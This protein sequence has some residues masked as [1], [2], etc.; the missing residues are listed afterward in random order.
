MT[1]VELVAAG[2]AATTVALST[3]ILLAA[4]GELVVE[5]SGVINVG[6]EGMM[7]AGAYF[8]YTS[9][10]G[11]TGPR[12]E[13]LAYALAAA[14]VAGA[15]LGAV[16]ALLALTFRADQVVV[17][18]AI[19]IVSLGITGVLYHASANLGSLSVSNP[20]GN[21]SIPVLEHVPVLG[22]ALFQQNLLV[23]A[24][25]LLTP[26]CGWYLT[27]TRSG[28]R[29]RA[30]G[31]Y[32]PAADSAG[33]SV[34]RVRAAALLLGGV[35]SGLAGAYL[36]TGYTCTFVQGMS[37]GKG[38]MALAVVIVGRWSAGG[39]LMASL[40]FGFAS[41]L[42]VQFQSTSSAVPYQLL[43]ALPYLITI[44]A[45]LARRRS[46]LAPMSLGAVYERG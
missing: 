28:L 40:L 27:K 24:A 36:S 26:L 5:R 32:P 1:G 41:A 39:I 37:S 19:N 18:T 3:P 46:A 38:F 13:A 4:L 29:L 10:Q 21:F 22:R 11:C 33:V 16:F 25:I 2:L 30:C 14:A 31:E 15:V 43:L 35:L 17:G 45:L 23:Y 12:W 6:M 8:A 20:I 9:A 7:L 42:Q 34:N 44:A